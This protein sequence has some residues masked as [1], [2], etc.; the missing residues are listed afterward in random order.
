MKR[1]V[2]IGFYE[3]VLIDQRRA[4][5]REVDTFARGQAGIGSPEK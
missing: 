2:G 5:I 4:R 3:A 1:N